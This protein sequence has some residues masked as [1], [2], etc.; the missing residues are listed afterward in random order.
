[1]VVGGNIAVFVA[2]TGLLAEPPTQV[3]QMVPWFKTLAPGVLV[4]VLTVALNGLQRNQRT[5]RY[6]RAKKKNVIPQR[7]RSSVSCLIAFA[8]TI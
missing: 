1:M 7:M 4:S 5:L 8:A 2:V 3:D 6:R